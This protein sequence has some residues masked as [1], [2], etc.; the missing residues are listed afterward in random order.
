M[1]WPSTILRSKKCT[2]VIFCRTVKIRVAGSEDLSGARAAAGPGGGARKIDLIITTR[3]AVQ[4]NQ[5]FHLGKY[6]AFF[7]FFSSLF[8]FCSVPELLML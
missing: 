4:R 1:P 2:K 8:H 3:V 5:Y 6:V 7:F